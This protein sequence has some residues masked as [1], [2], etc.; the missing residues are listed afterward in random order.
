V[1]AIAPLTRQQLAWRPAAHL[2]SVGELARHISFG[3]I[4]WFG[5]MDAPGSAELAARITAW[6]KDSDENRNIAESAFPI[7]EQ[8]AE[9]VH[10][11]EDTWQMIEL[12]LKTW[13]VSDLAKTYRHTWNGDTYAV[14]RQWTI[15]RMLTHDVHHGGQISLILGM[16]GIQAFELGD[17]FGH[18]TLPPLADEEMP[19]E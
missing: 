19:L 5:R 8:A 3:R 7:T 6:E 11:L 18:I 10:W 12:T 16:Q 13:D 9:L 15:W 1:N 4:T 17:L 14:S 2:N